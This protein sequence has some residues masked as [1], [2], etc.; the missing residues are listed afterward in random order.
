M[1]DKIVVKSKTLHFKEPFKIAYETVKTAPVVFLKITDDKGNFGLG[2]ACPDPEVTGETYKDSLKIIKNKLNKNFFNLPFDSWDAYHQ[3]VQ[4]EFNNYPA[5]QAAIQEAIIYLTAKINKKS[6]Y[7]FLPKKKKNVPI[8]ITIGIKNE[9]ETIADIKKRI[10]QGYEIIKLKCGLNLDQDISRIKTACEL[11]SKNKKLILDANQGY[12]YNQAQRLLRT[13]KGYPIDLIEQPI[14]SKNLSG[15]KKLHLM[16]SL[17]IIA[18]ESVVTYRDAEQILKGNYAAGVNI[19]LAKCGGP[20]NFIKIYDLAKKL[21]K[22]VMIGC[23]YES[24]ISMTTGAY[25]ALGLDLDYVD[26]DTGHLDFPDDP[27]IGGAKVKDGQIFIK[28]NLNL[29]KF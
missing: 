6:P 7:D 26:L 11:I 24:N 21:K 1:I 25:L 15:L 5:A 10:K 13:L 20:I 14:N 19:K 9:K 23:M 22:I 8:M 29:K 16:K 4:K 3:K 18:D 17:P 28:S 2:N 27:T 12:S